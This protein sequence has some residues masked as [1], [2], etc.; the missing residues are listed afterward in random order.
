MESVVLSGTHLLPGFLEKAR[1]MRSTGPCMSSSPGPTNLCSQCSE[2]G[3]SPGCCQAV[4]HPL[5][6][7]SPFKRLAPSHPCG[8]VLARE[9]DLC[10][11]AWV[12]CFNPRLLG[13]FCMEALSALGGARALPP[14]GS[15]LKWVSR[16]ATSPAPL[17]GGGF[18]WTRK[19]LVPLL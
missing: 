6:S 15:E 10:S 5:S 19:R 14:A 13:E 3:N 2:A 4:Q 17:H 1:R 9:A 16:R 7:S 11:G 8:P 12:V 18:R